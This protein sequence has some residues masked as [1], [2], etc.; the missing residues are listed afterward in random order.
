MI[1]YKAERVQSL[2]EAFKKTKIYILVL[3]VK[4][5]MDKK[6]DLKVGYKAFKFFQTS[7]IIKQNTCP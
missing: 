1:K 7:M 2:Y 3:D 4:L 6:H 5:Q